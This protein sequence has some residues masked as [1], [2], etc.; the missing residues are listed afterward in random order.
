MPVALMI[1]PAVEPVDIDALKEHSVV[2]F[3]DDDAYLTALSGVAREMVE[4]ESGLLFIEQEWKETLDCFHSAEIELSK[5]PVRSVESISYVDT[6]GNEQTLSQ[7]DYQVDLVSKPGLILPAYG[8][9]WP[10]VRQQYGAVKINYTCGFSAED[11]EGLVSVPKVAKQ[12]IMMLATHLYE[13]RDVVSPVA[14]HE[15]PCGVAHLI[16]LIRVVGL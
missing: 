12:A 16:G 7:A 14:L 13:N 3:A 5:A 9:C 15:F 8:K 10:S 11:E 6:D 4:R 1:A 2:D